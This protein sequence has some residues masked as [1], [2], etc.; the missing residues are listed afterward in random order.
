MQEKAPEVEDW[1]VSAP[2]APR[3]VVRFRGDR[4]LAAINADDGSLS[5]SFGK[6]SAGKAAAL[7]ARA[8]D[9][10][11]LGRRGLQY[12]RLDQLTVD[13]LLGVR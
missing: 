7:K 4:V 8:F 9:R 13:L 5:A 11:A 3:L 12:E 1:I 6:Y 2:F 10:A